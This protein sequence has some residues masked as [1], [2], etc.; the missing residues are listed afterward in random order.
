MGLKNLLIQAEIALGSNDFDKL[1]KVLEEL[2]KLDFSKFSKE[3]LREGLDILN[4]MVSEATEKKMKLGEAVI[5]FN[6][7][8]SYFEA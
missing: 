5:N 8:K 1:Q 6:R 3:E 4:H 2:E 7:F